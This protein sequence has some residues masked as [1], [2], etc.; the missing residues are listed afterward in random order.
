[1]FLKIPRQIYFDR[2]DSNQ[3]MKEK[4]R[5]QSGVVGGW[6]MGG[7]SRFQLCGLVRLKAIGKVWYAFCLLLLDFAC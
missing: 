4:N 6:D 7:R 5:K 2:G 1:M 3:E